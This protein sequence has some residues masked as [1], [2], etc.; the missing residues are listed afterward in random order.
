MAN[1]K[2]YLPNKSTSRGWS[3]GMIA[4][5]QAAYPGPNPGPRI[6]LKWKKQKKKKGKNLL[7][8]LGSFMIKDTN[9]F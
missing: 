4:A 9:C 1:F 7:Q 3:N 6:F 2:M 8:I 5:F